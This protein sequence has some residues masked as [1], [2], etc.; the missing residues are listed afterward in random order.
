MPWLTRGNERAQGMRGLKA[1]LMSRDFSLGERFI[2]L[3][4]HVLLR[5]AVKPVCVSD[6]LCL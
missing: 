6:R 1:I 5:R 4:S 3:C 2:Y